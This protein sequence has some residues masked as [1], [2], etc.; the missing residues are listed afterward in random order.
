MVPAITP[1]P[2]EAARKAQSPDRETEVVGEGA[3]VGTA[4]TAVGGGGWTGL[5]GGGGGSI[6]VGVGAGAETSGTRVTSF[7]VTVLGPHAEAARVA[8]ATKETQTLESAHI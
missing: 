5:V 2:V 4:G 8:A 3:G 7:A 1:P 6:G